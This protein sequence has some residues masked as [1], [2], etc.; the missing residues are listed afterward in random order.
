V[1]AVAG[2][3]KLRA[4]DRAALGARLRLP[5]R[6]FALL[7]LWRSPDMMLATL[8]ELGLQD[9]AAR[10]LCCALP[11]REVVWWACMCVAHTAPDTLPDEESRALRSAEAWVR[12]P[13]PET[14]RAAAQAGRRRNHVLPGHWAAAAASWSGRGPAPATPD[15]P[16]LP[17]RSGRAVEIALRL[18]A[19][20][21]TACRRPGR[22]GRFLA[23]G[24]DI[25]AGGLGRLPREA[26][27]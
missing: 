17:G 12:R 24:Q 20:R 6:H 3:G 18:A 27:A 26:A 4:I 14:R 7:D 22:L 21:E 10:L 5:H 15:G 16:A 23:S 13:G 1:S 19:L 9:E 11:E 25:A 8:L 2:G